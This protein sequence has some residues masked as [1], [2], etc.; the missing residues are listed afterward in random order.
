[1]TEGGS[2]RFLSSGAECDNRLFDELMLV[3]KADGT[4]DMYFR[5]KGNLAVSHSSDGGV[6]WSYGKDSGIRSPGSRFLI[7]RLSSGRLLLVNP[8]ESHAVGG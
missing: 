2:F 1:M 7:G 4:L 8:S 5:T 3:E 6:T